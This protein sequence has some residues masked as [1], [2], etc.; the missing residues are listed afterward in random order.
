MLAELKST[1]LRWSKWVWEE[2]RLS[3][4]FF[5]SCLRHSA[6]PQTKAQFERQRG[7]SEERNQQE[8]RSIG[9]EWKHSQEEKKPDKNK[10]A[11]PNFYYR[12]EY[13]SQQCASFCFLLIQTYCKL[14]SPKKELNG[15]SAA[16]SYIPWMWVLQKEMWANSLRLANHCCLLMFIFAVGGQTQLLWFRVKASWIL[17]SSLPSKLDPLKVSHLYTLPTWTPLHYYWWGTELES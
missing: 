9:S 7:V 15:Y 11:V 6:S 13:I 10:Q 14:H 8:R 16:E 1:G 2:G 3:G 17:S 5:F 12:A 4:L